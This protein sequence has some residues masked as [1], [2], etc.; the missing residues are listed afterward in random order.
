MGTPR[1]EEEKYMRRALALAERA[2]G[3]TAPNPMVGAVLVRHGCVVGEGYHMRAGEPHAEV[4]AL[5][6]A[7]GAARG[8]DLYV[9]LEPCCHQ[10]RTPAC[11]EALIQAGVARVVAA[12]RD[13]NP[14][15]N[16]GGLARLA[17]AAITVE[18]G[19]LEREARRQNEAF[20]RRHLTGLPF[21]TLKMAMTLDGKVATRAGD[22][23]WVTGE[24]ARR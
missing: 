16:G 2:R 14:S 18:C 8:A 13:P 12:T 1:P 11:T 10:G 6:Q 22:S 23:R 7:A 20:I 24:A 17:A 9:T 4:V 5:R 19:L 3:R 21:V 15:V